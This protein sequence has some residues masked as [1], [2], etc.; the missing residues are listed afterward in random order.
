[1]VNIAAPFGSSALFRV[2]ILE[3]IGLSR[4]VGAVVV[5]EQTIK[6]DARAALGDGGYAGAWAEGE[7]MTLAQ[8]SA[9]IL[10]AG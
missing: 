5:D 7:S 10:A 6:D 3:W 1:V 8:A 2:T 9:E 4:D